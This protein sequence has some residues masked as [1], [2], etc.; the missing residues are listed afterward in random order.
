VPLTQYTCVLELPLCAID[1]IYLCA[2]VL[3]DALKFLMNKFHT[4]HPRLLQTPNLT[5]DEQLE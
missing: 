5:L 4:T 2:A 1:T 3:Y